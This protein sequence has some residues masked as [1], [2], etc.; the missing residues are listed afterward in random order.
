MNKTY[1]GWQ[2]ADYVS[3]QKEYTEATPMFGKDGEL[4]CPGYA[5]HNVFQYDRNLVKHKMRRKEWDF[6]QLSNGEY[7]VQLSFANISLGGYV[8]LVLVDLKSGETLVSDMSVFLAQTNKY[9]HLRAMYLIMYI[10]RLEAQSLNL[11][12]Q[13][14]QEL[15]GS[16]ARSLSANSLWICMRI[17]RISQ[18]YSHLKNIQIVIS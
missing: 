2:E 1:V 3:A 10:S 18:Q 14:R 4:L 12:Q 16:R 8:S 9:S 13:T 17:T 11:I 7:M 6:Y 15:F 5:K